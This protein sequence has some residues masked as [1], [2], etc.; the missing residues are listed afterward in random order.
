GIMKAIGARSRDV[1]VTYLSMVLLVA[2]IALLIALPIAALC[3]WLLANQLAWLLNYDIQDSGVPAGVVALEIAA[4]IA[5]PLLASAYPVSAAARITVRE[6][7][8]SNPASSSGGGRSARLRLPIPGV[9]IAM[10]YAARSMFR[11][12]ARLALTLGAL[13]CGGAIEIAVL[14]TQA[15]LF[16]TLDQ[17]AA[18]WQQDLTVSFNQPERV[19]RVGDEARQVPG[20]VG[21]EQQ[22]VTLAVRPRPNGSDSE[23]RYAIYGVLPESTLLRPTLTKGRW[24]TPTDRDAIVVNVNFLKHEP[25]LDLGDRLELKIDGRTSAWRIVGVVTSH[26][27]IYGEASPDQ[28]AGFISARAFTQQIYRSLHTNRLIITTAEHNAAF[29]E[30]VAKA[31]EA[32]FAEAGI[33]ALVQTQSDI[34]IQIAGFVSLIVVLLLVM[35]LSFVAIGGLSLVGALSLNVLERTKEIGILRA[36]GSAHQRVAGIVVI[37]GLCI[38]VLSWIPATLLALPLSKGLSEILGWSL[39]NWPLVY[40]FPAAAPLLWIGIVVLLS[41]GASYLPA[42]QAARINVRDALEHQ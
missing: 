30:R 5:M 37:E 2:V 26:M 40:V 21:V 19:Q 22:P 38:G 35:A 23:Q 24:L 39:L 29:R 33:Q 10:L 15:S 36:I 28:G 3:S 25:G 31:L 42:R 32:H 7:L 20:V 41:V 13:A 34:K 17:V 27:L 6:A 8:T 16:A 14:S 4:G 9:P 18:Y 1:F 12:K 11:R